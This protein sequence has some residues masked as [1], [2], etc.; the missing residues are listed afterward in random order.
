MPEAH[1][2]A[3]LD[4]LEHQAHR[5]AN[6]RELSLKIDHEDL[7]R[8]QALAEAYGLTVDEIGSQLLHSILLLVEEKMP[9]RPGPG[10][11]RVED[12]EPVYEDIGPTPRY[13]AAKRRLEQECARTAASG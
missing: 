3:L 4:D 13:L 8:V 6:V 7:I 12:D 10:V 5:Q 9:Y 1:V 11:I 2:N